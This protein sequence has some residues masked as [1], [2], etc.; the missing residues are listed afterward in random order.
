LLHACREAINEF[1]PTMLEEENLGH[2]ESDFL[3]VN[4][5]SSWWIPTHKRFQM[6]R[7]KRGVKVSFNVSDI[8]S[9]SPIVVTNKWN[10]SNS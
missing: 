2:T 4:P 3:T 6:G 5:R 10:H 1:T 7:C 9:P 8:L